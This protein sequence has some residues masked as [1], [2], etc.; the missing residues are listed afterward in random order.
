MKTRILIIALFVITVFLQPSWDE[1]VFALCA[2]EVNYDSVESD[3]ELVFT[4]TVTRLDNY[5][6]PQKVTFLI[7]DVVK[8][9]VNTP[10]HVFENTGMVFLENDAIMSLSTDVDY[11]IGK[12][13]KVYVINGQTSQCTTNITTPPDG[14]IWEPGPEDGNYYSEEYEKPLRQYQDANERESYRDVLGDGSIVIPAQ[15]SNLTDTELDVAMDGLYSHGLDHTELPIASIA[16]DY[17][18][19]ILVLWTPDLTIGNKV[20]ELIGDVPFVLLYEESPA[21]WEHDGPSP[22]PIPE[23]EQ[24]RTVYEECGPRTV[25]QDG[26]CLVISENEYG[27]TGVKWGEPFYENLPPPNLEPIRDYDYGLVYV[28]V[29]L[30][31][32]IVGSMVGSIFVIRRKRK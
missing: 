13:Y 26:I 8:G 10:K 14:Y 4:G 25:L 17:K 28:V 16:I 23:P 22:E 32:A 3:S 30:T 9:D 1:Q 21:R 24:D 27:D 6:G 19:D 12:T 11:K 31:I 18:R 2:A 5:D 15:P 7:H 20:Q 29:L